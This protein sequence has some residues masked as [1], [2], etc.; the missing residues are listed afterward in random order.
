VRDLKIANTIC[1]ATSQRRQAAL[2]V[3]RGVDLML[4][5]GGRHSANTTRLAALCSA[6]GTPTHLVE[7][8]HEILP[9][10]LRRVRRVGVTGGASTPVA[11]IA[12]AVKRVEELA[13]AEG[14]AGR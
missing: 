14:E 9:E 13:E 1:E 5:I 11:A 8:A 12:E 7:S 10:W 3:A 2:R 4:V 6:A